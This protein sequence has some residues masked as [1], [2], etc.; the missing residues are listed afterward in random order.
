MSYNF[1]LFC[2]QDSGQTIPD[3]RPALSFK[4]RHLT[5][6]SPGNNCLDANSSEKRHIKNHPVTAIMKIS[7]PVYRMLLRAFYFKILKTK[8]DKRN[9]HFFR[10]KIDA[11]QTGA[12]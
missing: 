10:T 9:E 2:S 1:L 6:T 3:A 11:N 5:P 12:K 7:K 8:V 4:Q